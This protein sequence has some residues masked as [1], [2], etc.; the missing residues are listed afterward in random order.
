MGLNFLHSN[1]RHVPAHV[2]QRLPSPC[3]LQV[4]D[5]LRVLLRAC[6]RSAGSADCAPLCFG[7]RGV[8]LVARLSELTSYLSG[9]GLGHSSYLGVPTGVHVQHHD[10]GPESLRPYRDTD[11]ARILIAGRGSWDVDPHLE[12]S[13]E[14]HLPFREPLVLRSIPAN[15]LPY[16]AASLDKKSTTLQL[17]KLWSAKGLLRVFPGPAAERDLCRTFGSYKSEQADRMIG[18]RRGPNSLEGRLRGPSRFLPP[19]QV[20]TN[21]SVPR[22]T[23]ILVGASTDRADFYH[24]IKVSTPRA[25]SNRIGPALSYYDLLS[26]GLESHA[27]HLPRPLL[28][29]PEPSQFLGAFSALFQGDHGGVEYATAGHES[30]LTQAGLLQY[31]SRILGRSAVSQGSFWDGLII[32]DYFALSCEPL[33]SLPSQAEDLAAA[34]GQS[35]A[36]LAVDTAK[37]AYEA[38]GVVGSPHKDVL[39]SLSFRAGGAHIDSEPQTVSEGQVLVSSPPEKRLALSYLSLICASLPCLSQELASALA[40][41]WTSVLLYRRCLS[42]CLGSFFGVSHGYAENS[43]GSNLVALPRKAAQELA[44]LSALSPVIVSNVAVPFSPYAYCSD[45]SLAK[46]AVCVTY[47]G[48]AV[49]AAMWAHSGKKGFYTTLD[50]HRSGQ[51]SSDLLAGSGFG[52]GP[53][54]VR[55]LG[56]D[57]D[58]VEVGG[59]GALSERLSSFGLRV[60]PPF[61]AGASRYLCLSE[62]PAL[63]LLLYLLPRGRLR[64]LVAFAPDSHL[65]LHRMIRSRMLAVVGAACRLGV[66]ALFVCTQGC[67]EPAEKTLCRLAPVSRVDFA[68]CVFGCPWSANL[69]FFGAG[70]AFP[71]TLGGCPGCP[72]HSPAPFSCVAKLASLPSFVAFAAE[73]FASALAERRPLEEAPPRGLES[74]LTNDVLCSHQWFETRVWAWPRRNHINVLESEA[75]LQVYR[76]LC[77]AGGDLR[78]NAITDSSVTLGSHSKGRSSALLLGP[79]LRKAGAILVAGGLYPASH[80]SPTRLNPSDDPTRD[81][82]C[83]LAT[84]PRLASL[85]PPDQLALL[86]GLSKSRANWLRLFL[87]A[88]LPRVNSVEHRLRALRDY[89]DRPPAVCSPR[90]S[91]GP[92]GLDFD[93]TLGFPGEGPPLLALVALLFFRPCA[94]ALLPRDAADRA[95]LQSR[96]SELQVGRPVQSRT[97]T[98]RVG[99]SAAF[100]QWLEEV[101]GFSLEAL[102]QTKPFD[103]EDLCYWLTTYGRDLYN[104]GRP[105]WHYAE[106]VNAVTA[107][108]PAFRR[109]AQ[110]AWDLAFAWLAEE[111]YGHHTAMPLP[112]L[113]GILTTCL[114]WG[115]VREAGCF[116]LAWGALLRGGEV[117]KAFRRDLVFPA[118]ALGAQTFVL[119]RISEPKTRA[120]A[121]RHQAAKLEPLDL[122][123]V[124]QLA[125][126][127]LPRDAPLWPMSQQSLR[128]RFNLVLS[129]LGVDQAGGRE[130]ALDLGSLRPGGATFLLQCTEDSELV[131]RRGRWVSHK[132]MEIYLQEVAASTYIA[133][134]PQRARSRVQ[135]AAAVFQQT[136]KRARAWTAAG[137]PATSLSLVVPCCGYLGAK[138]NNRSCV[139]CF[140]WC[141][142]LGGCLQLLYCM[143][144][145]LF[146]AVLGVMQETCK[147]LPGVPVEQ[148]KCPGIVKGCE[149]MNSP[150]YDLS[151]YEGC[152]DYMV[153]MLPAMYAGLGIVLGFSCCVIWTERTSALDLILMVLEGSQRAFAA[154]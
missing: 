145:I 57:F 31:P 69:C 38:E 58:F 41:C 23:H 25:R 61:S 106:T 101:A 126:E 20:L 128:K 127:K 148:Q 118:D 30:L 64:S 26:A 71:A 125:F 105:Y 45:A 107:A 10:G 87:L 63:E 112:V 132:V 46:G 67:A 99:L 15:D 2:L 146:F 94:S 82:P 5:R 85:A 75:A 120:R 55:P 79:S 143:L 8:H 113:L 36:A 44:L 9:L 48:E 139:C 115:W 74:I 32:D 4:F 1:F 88:G 95:R 60:G 111:P 7:R 43:E 80:F 81:Q 121:A 142:C 138:N 3:Q 90:P 6:S 135:H 98:N 103:P 52:A 50:G 149:S 35:R 77:R 89:P 119:L 53:C 54:F 131:R 117:C 28:T 124:V 96:S 134:L 86:Q 151:K 144:I 19:G 40:G 65:G 130:K 66:P 21:V 154:A 68:S 137:I 133:D 73:A 29:G 72:S 76:D 100:S 122:V 152:Y 109:Q 13:P 136:L 59:S 39:G 11:P 16:P 93:S 150:D 123:Q 97:R 33:P 91:G 92:S 37:R 147:P 18:D 34:L 108:R 62:L 24:Q 12:W 14:L 102:L 141:N 153:E 110:G 83:R 22:Y 70:L 84:G 78:F 51:G 56:M 116:A 47:V 17:M 49:S 114:Y 104:S 42:S 27:S 129:C 140:A